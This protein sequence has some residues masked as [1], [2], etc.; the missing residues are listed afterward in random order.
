MGTG[1]VTMIPGATMTV[2]GAP[3]QWTIPWYN[4][5]DK[6]AIFVGGILIQCNMK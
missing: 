1:L 5:T 4:N 3:D 6:V 2:L